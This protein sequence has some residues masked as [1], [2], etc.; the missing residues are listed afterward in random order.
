MCAEGGRASR[1]R[2]PPD[3][4]VVAV[5]TSN[6]W[7][8]RRSGRRRETE[9]KRVCALKALRG[10]HPEAKLKRGK[11][12]GNKAQGWVGSILFKKKQ[13]GRKKKQLHWCI[14]KVRSERSET[15]MRTR[16]WKKVT[17]YTEQCGGRG[18]LWWSAGGRGP[19]SPWRSVGW[20]SGANLC[21]LPPLN[22]QMKRV[23]VRVRSS[24]CTRKVCLA[25]LVLQRSYWILKWGLCESCF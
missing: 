17:T 3:K 9:R 12:E 25:H 19:L 10:Q 4:K 22:K 23:S 15:V 11:R 1:Q 21:Q 24:H 14:R 20:G 13:R 8:K 2:K 5:E 16:E 6:D 18:C 7:G